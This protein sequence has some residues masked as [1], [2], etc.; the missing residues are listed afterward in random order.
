MPTPRLMD[1]VKR[2]V[3][4]DSMTF[5]HSY[6][7]PGSYRWTCQVKYMS[8][9]DYPK[10]GNPVIIYS[11]SCRSNPGVGFCSVRKFWSSMELTTIVS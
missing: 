10:Q 6:D 1:V 4:E 5:L 9:I 3:R 7:D 2:S 11:P 8:R